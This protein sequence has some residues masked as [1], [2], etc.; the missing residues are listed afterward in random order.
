MLLLLLRLMMMRVLAML[1]LRD[2]RCVSSMRGQRLMRLRLLLLLVGM[3]ARVG[4]VPRMRSMEVLVVMLR[5]LL[6]GMLMLGMVFRVPVVHSGGRR[7]GR[8]VVMRD[9]EDVLWGRS[10]HHVLWLLR[11]TILPPTLHLRRQPPLPPST[12]LSLQFG[13]PTTLSH[14]VVKHVVRRHCETK[15]EEGKTTHT[16]K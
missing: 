4:L 11:N 1:M 12:V 10:A 7:Q 3:Q 15:E 6:M 5:L 2:V 13:I 9:C 8:H 16:T 14:S